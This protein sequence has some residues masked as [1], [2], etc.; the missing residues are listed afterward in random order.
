[1]NRF[2]VID[3]LPFFPIGFYLEFKRWQVGG[4]NFTIAM[5]K[6]VANGYN[7]PLPYRLESFLFFS[8][9]FFKKSF[10]NKII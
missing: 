8:F 2:L 9:L 3:D 7:T 1:L 5:F 4:A 6:E 10:N